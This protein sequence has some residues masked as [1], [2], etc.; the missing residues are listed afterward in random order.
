MFKTHVFIL[1]VVFEEE[2]GPKH[3]FHDHFAKYLIGNIYS[4][5]V[6]EKDKVET[7]PSWT[8]LRCASLYLYISDQ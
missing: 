7:V 6:L 1:A 3:R 8:L 4:E 2:N 5:D